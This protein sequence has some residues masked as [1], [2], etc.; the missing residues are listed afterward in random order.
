MMRAIII[1]TGLCLAI[2]IV[3][4]GVVASIMEA[5]LAKR[6]PI[7]IIDYRPIATAVA[8]GEAPAAIQPYLSEI[9]RRAAAYRDAGYVVI[10]A[11]SIEAAPAD[12]FVPT[13]DDLPKAWLDQQVGD[14]GNE[15]V[16]SEGA[17]SATRS[18]P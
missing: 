13:P 14:R 6:P 3:G 7:V 2:T 10:N 12:V 8:A 11:A 17:A 15:A 1:G 4:I 18:A 5:E 9:K 16:D